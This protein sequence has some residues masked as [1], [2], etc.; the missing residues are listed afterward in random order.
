MT[1]K[2]YVVA[3]CA[4]LEATPQI[5]INLN[6]EEILL[7]REDEDYYAVSYYCSHEKLTL[8][9]GNITAGCIT[10]PYHGAEFRLSDGSVMAPPAL[11]PIKTFSTKVENG[12]I[13][14]GLNE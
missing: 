8:E 14:V 2:Y 12:T 1:L 7:C 3:A 6:G 9:G 4:E 10:C 5:H 11:K 13:A